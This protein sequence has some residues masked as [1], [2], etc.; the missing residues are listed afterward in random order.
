MHVNLMDDGFCG[1]EGRVRGLKKKEPNA[2]MFTKLG[3]KSLAANN[4]RINEVPQK[5]W[6]GLLFYTHEW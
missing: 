5:Q 2:L 1:G 3:S 4:Y 6:Q